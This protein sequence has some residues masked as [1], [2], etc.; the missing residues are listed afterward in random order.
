[1][2]FTGFGVVIAQR[3]GLTAAVTLHDARHRRGSLNLRCITPAPPPPL[4]SSLFPLPPLPFFLFLCLFLLLFPSSS[5]SSFYPSLLHL[6]PPVH[7]HFFS[8][9]SFHS[10]FPRSFPIFFL[11]SFSD[12][13]HSRYLEYDLERW[14]R[15][16]GEGS[17]EV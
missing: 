4:P 15:E 2:L 14:R 13:Y 16:R 17:G 7:S 9:S 11:S 6:P 1:M 12:S 10:P 3:P 5:S 8:S